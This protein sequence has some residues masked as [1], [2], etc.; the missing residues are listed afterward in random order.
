MVGFLEQAGIIV[1]P[2]QMSVWA[3]PTAVAAFAI[4]GARLLLFDRAV[5]REIAAAGDA[6]AAQ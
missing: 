2:L 3:I 4:H 1:E 6:G 5:R